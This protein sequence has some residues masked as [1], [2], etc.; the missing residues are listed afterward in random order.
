ML[1]AGSTGAGIVSADLFVSLNW[2][3]RRREGGFIFT[4]HAGLGSAFLLPTTVKSL[5]EIVIIDCHFTGLRQS[6]LIMVTASAGSLY[7][8]QPGGFP[9]AA[10]QLRLLAV[11]LFVFFA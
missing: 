11:T 9:P 4:R 5:I 6:G 1:F 8:E 2:F 7:I 3:D 10:S